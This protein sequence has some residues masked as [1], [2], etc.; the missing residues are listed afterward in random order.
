MPSLVLHVPAPETKCSHNREDQPS[1][2]NRVLD[3][4]RNL[5]TCVRLK[6]REFVSLP[7]SQCRNPPAACEASRPHSPRSATRTLAPLLRSSSASESPT[8]PPPITITSQVFT[9]A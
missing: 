3:P 4:A 8:M 5:D 6:S 2:R 7:E 9:S 1:C